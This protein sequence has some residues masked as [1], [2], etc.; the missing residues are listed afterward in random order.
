MKQGTFDRLKA[1]RKELFESEIARHHGRIFKLMGDGLLAEFGSVVEAVEC[2]VSL[3]RGMTERNGAVPQ[4]QRLD[5]RIG[6]N[7]G[8]VIVE[9]EDRYG[10]GVNVATRLEQLAEPG[11]IWVSGKVAKEVE[12]KLTFGFEPMGEQKVKNIVEPV[13][14]FR[15]K[16]DGPP[17]SR[18]RPAAGRRRAAIA[19][20]AALFALTAG[21]VAGWH[22]YLRP[23]AASS[24]GSDT[25]AIAVLPFENMSGDSALGYLGDGIADD[26]ITALSRFPDLS[27]IARNSSFAYKGTPTD[28]RKIGK[29]LGVGYVLEGSV[30][31]GDNEIRIV[32]QLIDAS[33]GIH[34]WADR[35]DKSGNDPLALQD[36]VTTRI[37]AT[38]AGE[39]GQIKKADYHR[40]WGKDSADLEEY[41]YYLRGHDYFMQQETKESYRR[42]AEI[43]EEG[44]SKFPNSTLLKVKLGF[45]HFFNAFNFFSDDMESDYRR[46]A[47]LAREVLASKPLTPQVA[48]LAHMLMAW[49]H[50]EERSF[51]QAIVEAEKAK[52]LAPN[53]AGT[54]GFLATALILSGRPDQG[55][56][57]SKEALAADPASRSWMNYR[58]GLAYSLKGEDE[59]SVAALE[60]AP[61][62]PDIL[63]LRA[64]GLMRLGRTEEAQVLYDRAREANPAFTQATWRQGYFYSDPAIV[65]R[66]VADLAKLGLPEK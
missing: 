9:G 10:E 49:V 56:E 2:A 13:P 11:G 31:K 18:L 22:G 17:G 51:E 44:L 60:E 48:R 5:I 59:S 3:Q 61:E 4:D 32:A 53:D 20:A 15:V 19:A 41:D 50:V 54:S 23:P 62:W 14:A 36:E 57:W 24:S 58:F 30:R 52:A 45:Y 21:A 34:V 7:L 26:I 42:A 27:V 1:H 33:D 66:Q 47:E 37:V 25:P 63:L 38:L 12:K 39:S 29:E 28:V 35:F 6:I 65:E 40:A 43:W 55:I 16:L 46:G 64:I 8:E